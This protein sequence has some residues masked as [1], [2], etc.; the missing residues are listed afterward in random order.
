MHGSRHFTN[1]TLWRSNDETK[2]LRS[3]YE[4]FEFFFRYKKESRIHS[5]LLSN[6]NYL[7]SHLSKISNHEDFNMH[8]LCRPSP[9]IKFSRIIKLLWKFLKNTFPYTQ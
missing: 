9:F 6:T 2:L 7:K 3:R 8:M 5:R 1:L 4:N